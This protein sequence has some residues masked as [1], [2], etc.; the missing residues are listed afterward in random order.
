MSY[1][2]YRLE[3]ALMDLDILALG[4]D[5]FVS[6]L[7]PPSVTVVPR[8]PDPLE[9]ASDILNLKWKFNAGRMNLT[10]INCRNT[11]KRTLVSVN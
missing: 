1:Q 8:R 5:S 6:F 4:L 11:K 3:E 9:P 7:A 2:H 10:I